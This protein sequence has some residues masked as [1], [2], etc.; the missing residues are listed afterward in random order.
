MTSLSPVLDAAFTARGIKPRSA[1]AGGAAQHMPPV[2]PVEHCE[3]KQNRR[4]HTRRK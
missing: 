4:R 2:S 1:T 3:P